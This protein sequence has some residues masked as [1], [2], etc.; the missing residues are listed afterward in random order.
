[1]AKFRCM[2]CMEEFDDTRT[3][4][5]YCGFIKGTPAN[6]LYHLQ[7]ESILAGRYI[8]GKVIGFGG[9]GIT[10]IAW[11]SVLE[12]K[13]AIKEYLP[14]D[15]ATRVPG[16]SQV[17]VYGGER[18]EQ[19]EAGLKSFIEEAQRLAK[20]ESID[21]IVK[22]FD[23]F[24]ENE[25]AYIIMEFLD[26]R[27]LK[28]VLKEKGKI[29]YQEAIGYILPV[30]NAL[31]EVHKS[32]II[33]RDIAPD[34]IFISKDGKVSLIDFGAA[35]YATTL[36][37]KSL[38]VI[39]KPGYAPEEQYRTRGNQG[40][41]S[42]VYAIA[43]TLYR[44]IT[45][46]VPEES[47]ERTTDDS[48][49]EPSKLGVEIPKSLENAIMN[50]LN[51]KAEDRIQTAK[52]F[53]DA[54]AGEVEVER[55]IIKQKKDDVGKWPVWQ[56]GLLFGAAAAIVAVVVLITTGVIKTPF[57]QERLPN[58]VE[59]SIEEAEKSLAP[60]G[61]NY[62][63]D[64]DATEAVF[65]DTPETAAE[66]E[67]PQ[68]VEAAVENV[69]L[70]ADSSVNI[71]NIDTEGGS[72]TQNT[73]LESAE[74]TE[75][76]G[77]IVS[78]EAADSS[79][80]INKIRI[81]DKVYDSQIPENMI[82][83]QTPNAG[84]RINKSKYPDVYLVL[85]AGAESVFLPD[86]TL[87]G[88]SKEDV[89]KTL[90][91]LGLIVNVVEAES[92]EYAP[93][94]VIST[95]FAADTKL[96]KG[97]TVTITVSIGVSGEKVAATVP[98]VV[99]KS[100]TDAKADINA[101]KLYVAIKSEEFSETIPKG[102]I[103]SQDPTGGSA[104]T[105]NETV[106]SLIVSKGKE[107]EALVRV[108]DVVNRKLETAI[109]T[110]TNSNLQYTVQYAYSNTIAYGTIISQSINADSKVPVGTKLGLVVSK[111]ARN[112]N[113][114]QIEQATDRNEERVTETITSRP[115]KTTSAPIVTSPPTT[116]D[117]RK[118]VPDVVSLTLSTAQSKLTDFNV[119]VE[120]V[121]SSQTAKGYVV[122]QSL[123]ADS[124]VNKGSA[125]T[126]KVSNGNVNNAWF[127]TTSWP[128]TNGRVVEYRQRYKK[129]T[130]YYKDN[131]VATGSGSNY[132]CNFYTL[133]DSSGHGEQHQGS[134][135]NSYNDYVSGYD[136]GDTKRVITNNYQNDQYYYFH[137]CRGRWLQ[138]GPTNSWTC[139]GGIDWCGGNYGPFYTYH[140]Y[141]GDGSHNGT[142]GIAYN[143]ENWSICGDSKYFQR[144][145][146]YYEAWTD[147]KNQ[148][149][150]VYRGDWSY[151][152]S[153]S[154]W[155]ATTSSRSA[156]SPNN[157]A[158]GYD[159][160]YRYR[161]DLPIYN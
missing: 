26:G 144:I 113:T 58:V 44:A 60:Y 28:S 151:T 77:E 32:G 158:N 6:E 14:S 116:S 149:Y 74:S 82:L 142:S 147:Y 64:T 157:S 31:N 93:G 124:K 55:V 83:A 101:A 20:F 89:V 148:R 45:G 139:S 38:S 15:F 3:E 120:Y 131:W 7:P 37:S 21:G 98:D 123:A 119:K 40:P 4:C 30:L 92:A 112:D 94:F 135:Y 146:V 34:N 145:P 65:D 2:G 141:I 118:R 126:I 9:F 54:L 91:D 69:G 23:S 71:V 125:I 132:Y 41:W 88:L 8:I 19:F 107:S 109:V 103:I 80:V 62:M 150:Y 153:Y 102:C 122:W 48:L 47:L 152:G 121:Y 17:S 18:A 29:S 115:E 12:K 24:I 161:E 1:M 56:K 42:D 110:I 154:G 13:V 35:R 39:L 140:A 10:Y 130:G 81:E 104:G 66:T 117:T 53:A 155:S 143:K 68:P 99:G 76:A 63:N 73:D 114:S 127:T 95:E 43:A 156:S 59:M 84:S 129:Q 85:S 97:D 36:H 75:A 159:I 137:W 136:N 51:I 22:I 11:D 67:S 128:G 16:Q 33:H 86:E 105:T 133:H 46:K 70:M 5:P 27:T 111:G 160:E 61:Y 87:V 138:N 96:K 49:K 100:L 57:T 52:E 106:V 108:P 50:A 78:D 79:E 134:L 25:T 90:E 72:D